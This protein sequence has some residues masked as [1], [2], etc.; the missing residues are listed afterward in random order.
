VLAPQGRRH[1][2][3]TVQAAVH[4]PPEHKVDYSF[5]LIDVSQAIHF[6]DV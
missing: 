2:G 5:S 6:C 3:L 4:L 1:F